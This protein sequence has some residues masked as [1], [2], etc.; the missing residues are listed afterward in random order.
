MDEVTGYEFARHNTAKHDIFA[1]ASL[2][3][4][5]KPIGRERPRGSLACPSPP[6]SRPPGALAGCSHSVTPREFV[7][8]GVAAA[9]AR[10]SHAEPNDQRGQGTR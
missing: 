9:V 4:G 3:C 2:W 1:T 6:T 10:P 5:S 8:R 7:R